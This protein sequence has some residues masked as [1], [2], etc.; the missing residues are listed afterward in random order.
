MNIVI[1]EK[2][3]QFLQQKDTKVM[4]VELEVQDNCCIPASFPHVKL[5]APNDPQKYDV[6][7]KDGFTV[8]LYKGAVVKSALKISLHNYLLFKEIEVSGITMI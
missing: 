7:E 3:K 5:G 1:D 2:V 4:T 6:F 8:Y